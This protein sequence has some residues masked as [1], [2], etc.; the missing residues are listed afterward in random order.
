MIKGSWNVSAPNGSI[1]VQD[2][3][4][5]NGVFNNV[6]YSK[7]TDNSGNPL[8]Y[9]GDHYFNYDPNAALLLQAGDSVEFTGFE[10]PHSPP[11]PADPIPFILPPSLQVITGSGD[12]VLDQDITLFP[13]PYGVLKLD[14]GGDF[15]GN[16]ADILTGDSSGSPAALAMSN[17]GISWSPGAGL[18]SVNLAGSYDGTTPVE[19]NNPNPV[20]IMVG[21]S[22]NN[23]DIN[24][25]MVTQITVGGDINNVGFQ[26]ANL[27]STDETYIHVGG[28]IFNSPYY[29][30]VQLPSGIV[31]ANSLDPNA[32]DSVFD[33]ALAPAML[34]TLE[35]INFDAPLPQG[36]TSISEYLKY[37]NFL[38]FPSP[39]ISAKTDPIGLGAN[40]GFVFDPSSNELGF[41]GPMSAALASE[42]ESGTFTVLVVNPNGTPAIDASGHI[43]TETYDFSAASS[44]NNLYLASQDSTVT[45]QLGY[46]VSGPGLFDINAASIELGNS[47]GILSFGGSVNVNVAGD[48]TMLTS[49]IASISGGYVTVN[50]GGEIDLSLG[51]NDFT[52]ANNSTPCYGIYTT[53]SGDVT[54]TAVGNVNIGSSRIG[55]FNGGN[56][57]IESFDGDVNA[58][59]G[60]N[61]ALYVP[62]SPVS[63]LNPNP[64]QNFGFPETS[65]SIG[66][67]VINDD[68]RPYGSGILAISPISLYQT[69]GSSGLPGDITVETP[70]GNIISTLGGISQFALNNDIGGG[71]TITL[72]AGT[73]GIPASPAQGNI[74]L[75]QGGVLGGTVNLTA[76]GNIQ[77][78]VVSRQ[79]ANITAVQNISA[80]VLSGGNA[81][82]SGGGAV[83]GTI[84]GI[85]GATVS[86]GEGVT[87]DVQSQKANVNG[88]GD[89]TLGGSAGGTA[90]G[91]D[92]AAASNNDTQQ[93]VA[94]TDGT[95]DDDKK[96]KKP[97]LQ[98]TKRVTVILPAS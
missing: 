86:G 94:T 56:V 43:E 93:Q 85:G 10:A 58:G 96:K 67:S 45:P 4:N 22:I 82:V 18:P 31:S 19:L 41:K 54:V 5:P 36:I 38:L 17:G 16:L 42:L 37:Y 92:A 21:G 46:Q 76:Q 34:A 78:L 7:R 23:L 68:A 97:T 60:A 50:A 40:P 15:T 95:D 48:L 47:A 66:G 24:T 57:F 6:V 72:T 1:Y 11:D 9:A 90:A 80:T 98:R 83:S 61:D 79:D 44:I 52:P 8:P 77:G 14:I 12:F 13:S 28:A 30:T 81:N 27:H 63:Y 89:N 49:T 33:L 32:W 69:P 87:A 26:G 71:P 73:P 62:V 88:I 29:S 84:I 2:V 51:N 25:T 55:A 35:A 74:L 59:N 75:G 70:N 64:G 39:S 53:G 3:R 20:Q 65:S 91:K